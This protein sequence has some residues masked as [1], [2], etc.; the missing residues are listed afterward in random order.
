MHRLLTGVDRAEKSRVVEDREMTF[1]EASA[2]VG[3]NTLFETV[4]A[5][6]PTRP[7]GHGELIAVGVGPGRTRWIVLECAPGVEFPPCPRYAR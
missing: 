2:G 4:D 5:P 6:P 7:A 1:V 3:L